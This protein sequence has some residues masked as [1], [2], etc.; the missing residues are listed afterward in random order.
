MSDEVL[1]E[2]RDGGIAMVTLNRPQAM[3]ALSAT[4]RG[5]ARL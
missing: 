4:L 2:R 5:R 3:N 1:L